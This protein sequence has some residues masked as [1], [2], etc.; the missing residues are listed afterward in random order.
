MFSFVANPKY[1]PD[2]YNNIVYCVCAMCFRSII[3]FNP[4]AH[5]E[6]EKRASGAQLL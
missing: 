1:D 4:I 6:G 2:D 3:I 5:R